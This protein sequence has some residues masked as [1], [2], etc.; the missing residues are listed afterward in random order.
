[1]IKKCFL[2]LVLMCSFSPMLSQEVI[3]E[4]SL[5]NQTDE[6]VVGATVILENLQSNKIL[7]Y[8]TSDSKGNF[9]LKGKDILETKIILKISH[10]NYKKHIDTLFIKDEKNQYD[11]K[12][13]ENLFE[14]NEVV[15]ISKKI[16]DTMKIPTDS[17]RLTKRSTLRN[18]LDQTDGFIVSDNGGITFM[19]KKINKVLINKKEVFIDQNKVAL[20]NIDYE[21]I[22]KMQVI[23][24]YR[25]KFNLD[26]ENFTN[27]V[28]NIDTKKSFKGVLKNNAEIGAGIKEEGLIKLK[29]LYFSDF[30]NMF[31]TSSNNTIGEK[32]FGFD[33]ISNSFKEESSEIFRK[34]LTP[35]FAEDNLL[36]TAFDSNSSL[37]LRKENMNSRIGLIMYYNNMDQS[38]VSFE[39]TK[40]TKQQLIKS[41]GKTRG[42]RGNSFLANLTYQRILNKA[43][44]VSFMSD[45]SLVD[46][47][48]YDDL[49]IQNVIP[50]NN[51]IN[52]FNSLQPESFLSSSAFSFRTKIGQNS[53]LSSQLNYFLENTRYNFN[54]RYLIGNEEQF[55]HQDYTLDNDHLNLSVDLERK[56]SNYLSL[57]IGVNTKYFD[58][59]LNDNFIRKGVR[60]EVFSQ[61]R[62][63]T[64]KLDYEAS[65]TPQFF[66]FHSKSGIEDKLAISAEI[67]YRTDERNRFSVNYSKSNELID[68][69]TN[70]D[71]LIV[72]FNNRL[73]NKNSTSYNI[74]SFE[75]VKVSYNYSS[76][77]KTQSFSASYTF[78][79][80]RNYLQPFFDREENN[81]FYYSNRLVPKSTI[82][83]YSV[84]AGKGFYFSE[85]YH[86]LKISPGFKLQT[87]QFP[88]YLPEKAQFRTTNTIFE[89]GLNLQPKKFFLNQLLFKS[90]IGAQNLY[91]NDESINN[92]KNLRFYFVFSKKNDA[93]EFNLKIG[94]NYQKTE[95]YNFQTPILNF[96]STV[97]IT[98]R[99]GL[100]SKGQYLFHLL[101]FPNTEFTA[102]QTSSNGNLIYNNFHKSNL[103]YFIVGAF[104]K[105]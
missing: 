46:M 88:T 41:E 78:S 60:S 74:S 13:E 69:D 32:E 71:T 65:I 58:D 77:I 104:Y 93:F 12:L 76:I 66:I 95:D 43:T 44:I 18:I 84:R 39:N 55:L 24:N 5:S 87:R 98:D 38:E 29:S 90:Q 105:F 36:K 96:N 27:S 81:I 92:S 82:Q 4:G 17:L 35:F 52:E 54:S 11:L 86:M 63:Q 68:L 7:N 15:L 97:E 42:S 101:N 83:N 94:K 45:L 19:G 6:P 30:L 75:D 80:E 73:I 64:E 9:K 22:D 50:E 23:N 102:F 91:L 3:I 16:R 40:T 57:S 56:F 10:L 34:S 53:I 62:G 1:M 103:N 37:I 26:F 47:K 25:D 31:F 79:K 59:K 21:M 70:I 89:L 61:F 48:N 100:F 2:L 20:D 67:G 99:F 51:Q 8:A 85:K 28:I 49:V 14:L 72:S 33:A